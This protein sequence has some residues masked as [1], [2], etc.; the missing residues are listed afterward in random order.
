MGKGIRFPAVCR[1]TCNLSFHR[2]VVHCCCVCVLRSGS[3]EGRAESEWD[4]VP[5]TP[6][7]PDTGGLSRGAAP[8][9]CWHHK[10]RCSASAPQSKAHRPFR[11]TRKNIRCHERPPEPCPAPSDVRQS[12]A[13]QVTNAELTTK[14][15]PPKPGRSPNLSH[16]L[17]RQR[18]RRT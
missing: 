12:L 3:W 18:D 16:A 2:I 14:Q 11:F 15:N 1:W 7:R 17:S 10:R 8:S 4:F 13:R 9:E 5:A 6:P